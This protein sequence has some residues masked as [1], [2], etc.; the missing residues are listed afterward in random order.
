MVC[1]VY[2]AYVIVP[3][4][5]KGAW[6]T[7]AVDNWTKTPER[8]KSHDKSERH[9][10]AVEKRMLSLSAEQHSNVVEE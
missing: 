8:L 4:Q 9:L 7:R 10:A 3:S 2:K 1:T 6:V 5:A